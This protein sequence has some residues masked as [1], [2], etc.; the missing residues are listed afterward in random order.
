MW[1]E[2]ATNFCIINGK[3]QVERELCHVLQ[4]D[5]AVFHKGE[6]KTL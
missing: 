5:V 6:S 2:L 3:R 4:I 1:Y